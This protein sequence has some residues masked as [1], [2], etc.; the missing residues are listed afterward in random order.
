MDHLMT[1][2]QVYQIKGFDSLHAGM[3]AADY[4]ISADDDQF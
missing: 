3:I 2:I 1:S 4:T